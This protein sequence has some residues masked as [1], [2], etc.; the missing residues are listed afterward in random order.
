MQGQRAFI[1]LVCEELIEKVGNEVEVVDGHFDVQVRQFVVR[2]RE[3]FHSARIRA[4]GWVNKD[5]RKLSFSMLRRV[6]RTTS[7]S[8]LM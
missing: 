4:I 1:L 7:N 2:K 5:E 3:G 6:N 8:S